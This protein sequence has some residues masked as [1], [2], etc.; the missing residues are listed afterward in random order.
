MDTDAY[1]FQEMKI[2][3]QSFYVLTSFIFQ[4]QQLALS[5]IV[6]RPYKWQCF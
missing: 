3:E 5:F 6:F 1:D 2:V 4:S